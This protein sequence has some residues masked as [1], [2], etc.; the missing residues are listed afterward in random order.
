VNLFDRVA[1]KRKQDKKDGKQDT[2]ITELKKRIDDAEKQREEHARRIG[3]GD[4]R[5]SMSQGGPMIRREYD[6]DFSRLGPRFAQGDG[7]QF[8]QCS[9]T[10]LT[11]R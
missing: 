8:P 4:L 6:R 3:S 10:F 1:D 11:S 7:K 9:E 2:E 5:D